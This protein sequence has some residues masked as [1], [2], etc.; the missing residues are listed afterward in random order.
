MSSISKLLDIMRQL[1]DPQTGCP[2]DLE[3]DFKS[4]APYTIEEAYEVADAIERNDLDDLKD[5]LGD[6]LLQVVFHSQMANEAE[7][8]NFDD[9]VEA[10]CEKMTRRHPHVFAGKSIGDAE[11]QAK[12]WEAYKKQERLQKRSVKQS[13]KLNPEN[14]VLSSVTAKLPSLTRAQKLTKQAAKVGFDWSD[15]GSVM[16]KVDEELA[17]LK[18]AIASS[19]QEHITEEFGDLMFVMTNLARKLK[20]D[21][22]ASLRSAN[23]KFIRRFHFIER[24]LAA[25]SKSLESTSLEEMDSLWN[26]AKVAEKTQ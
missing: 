18:E 13:N 25:Q 10:I 7:I 23:Q 15:A 8:F 9:V 3:Q 14:S 22:D 20:I 19:N 2:W 17:E 11:S 16:H 4:I 21:P 12:N 6:L 5:E 26:L 1:R 24:Q